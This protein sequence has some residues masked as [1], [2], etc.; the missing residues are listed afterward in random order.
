[1]SAND[2]ESMMLNPYHCDLCGGIFDDQRPEEE[3][4]REYESLFT[5][6]ERAAEPAAIVCENC[7]QMIMSVYPPH[8]WRAD[9]AKKN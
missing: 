3:M 8:K 4:R 7:W 1:V 5:P 2:D 9:Q 6:Q